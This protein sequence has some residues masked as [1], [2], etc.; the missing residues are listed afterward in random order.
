[1]RHRV[2]GAATGEHI[3][4]IGVWDPVLPAHATLFRD[5]VHRAAAGGRKALV[6]TLDPPP[7]AQLR[8]PAQHPTFHDRATRLF[9]QQRCGV[10]TRVTIS[11]TRREVDE[12]GAAWLLS[13]LCE[14]VPIGELSLGLA[15]SFGRGEPGGGRAIRRYCDTHGI[16]VSALPRPPVVPRVN[17]AREHLRNGRLQK[18][19]SLLAQPLYWSRPRSWDACLPWCPGRYSAVPVRTPTPD[20]EPLAE[21]FVVELEPWRGLSRLHWPERAF[22]WLAFVSGPGDAVEEPQ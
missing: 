1:V 17:E 3:A 10:Q 15:Q 4:L 18:A 9:V 12:R 19:A 6:V 16:R 14:L 21:P 8:G 7:V 20:A 2:Y 13:R 22:P 5:T 11:L